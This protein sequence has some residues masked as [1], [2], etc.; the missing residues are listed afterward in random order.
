VGTDVNENAAGRRRVG[1]KRTAI[2]ALLALL[3]HAL[4]MLV[5]LLA[6]RLEARLSVKKRP[7]AN[8]VSL[9]SLSSAQWAQNRLP[10]TSQS[11]TKP[12]PSTE[13]SKKPE[14]KPP[15]LPKGQVVD[16]APGNNQEAPDAKFLAE[17]NNKV[18]HE[19]R[20]KDT[21]PF[22]RNAMPRT[23]TST[24]TQGSGTAPKQQVAGNNG[25]GEDDR[26][27]RQGGEQKRAM[28]IP[29]Q[30]SQQQVAMRETQQ[31]GPGAHVTN[32][33]ETEAIQGNSNRL[34]LA[35]GKEG[36]PDEATSN[37][38]KGAPGVVNLSPTSST[39]DKVSGAAPNDHLEDVD[40]GDG[41][42]LNTREWK[43]AS[44]FNR[45]KQAIGQRWNPGEELHQ[46]D[47]T[48]NI[49]GG[50][51]RYTVLEITLSAQGTVKDIH[52]QKSSGVEFLDSEAIAAVQRAQ[53]FPNPPPGLMGSDSSVR[54]PFG[55]FLEMNGGP[56]IRLF[57]EPN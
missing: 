30:K 1:S 14:V 29:T 45:V 55:F 7:P 49:Y 52:V 4:F 15:P 57:R 38:R 2:A 34:K 3:F 41:T 39:L 8:A 21:T 35:P 56:K 51:D 18:Q 25:V 42:L 23:T 32:R 22:Y 47:P 31:Q 28:E 27:L 17:H 36:G 37:G 53:P 20:A 6:A 13:E 43:Y 12:A 19:T 16:V 54:F 40:D 10:R 5:I 24:P 46:R 26:P 33:T 44:F 48:L 9:R 11:A 50:R